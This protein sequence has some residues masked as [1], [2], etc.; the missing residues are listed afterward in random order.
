VLR[1]ASFYKSGSKDRQGRRRFLNIGGDS[2][3]QKKNS[4]G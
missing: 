2:P 3:M 4:F 1:V